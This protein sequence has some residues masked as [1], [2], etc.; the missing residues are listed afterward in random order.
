VQKFEG[1]KR[2]KIVSCPLEF[3]GSGSN[4]SAP[5]ET[6]C[7]AAGSVKSALRKIP[8]T[9]PPTAA[10]DAT[11]TSSTLDSTI[12]RTDRVPL[13]SLTDEEIVTSSIPLLF[14][15]PTPR[16]LLG[17]REDVAMEGREN[18]SEEAIPLME[19]RCSGSAGL[20]GMGA[21]A[22]ASRP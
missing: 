13:T 10:D 7:R 21:T 12:R 8:S 16:L 17:R 20:D 2:G 4:L 18:G 9:A 1:A 5:R 11:T 22:R 6:T 19:R 14:L 3:Q 15:P